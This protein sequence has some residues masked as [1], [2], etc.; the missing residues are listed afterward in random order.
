MK[1]RELKHQDGDHDGNGNET[2]KLIAENK[3]STWICEI[4][5]I[6]G[7]SCLTC[8]KA[9]VTLELKKPAKQTNSSNRGYMKAK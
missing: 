4:D 7:S 9:A 5:T 6:S 1:N 8:N 2:T 3:R